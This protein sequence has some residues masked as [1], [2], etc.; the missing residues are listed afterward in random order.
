MV[1]QPPAPSTPQEK[2]MSQIYLI[3]SNAEMRFK[4]SKIYAERI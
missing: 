1:E 2:E 3:G 4:Q